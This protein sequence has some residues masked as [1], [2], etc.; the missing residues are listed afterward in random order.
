MSRVCVILLKSYNKN[1]SGSS[2]EQMVKM[3]AS[4]LSVSPYK[5]SIELL[6]ARGKFVRERYGCNT[7]GL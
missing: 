4:L 6:K 1:K 5:Y 7:C 3:V 2:L